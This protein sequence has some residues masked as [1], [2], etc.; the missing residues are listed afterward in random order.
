M[1]YFG[2][3]VTNCYF[4]GECLSEI[5]YF[6]NIVGVCGANVYENN[7]YYMGTTEYH[8]FDG[9]CY[10]NNSLNAFGAT[11]AEDETFNQTDENKGATA[12][13]IEEIQNSEIY[14]SILNLLKN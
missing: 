8:N 5:S 3:C 9:N 11:V 13:T 7:L 6:G 2:G 1:T 4:T 12:A 14:Q 10:L